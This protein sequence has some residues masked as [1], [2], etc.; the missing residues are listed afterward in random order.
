MV[1]TIPC[2]QERKYS[3]P[4]HYSDPEIKQPQ[5]EQSVLFRGFVPYPSRG[6]GVNWGE[7]RRKEGGRATLFHYLPFYYC[8]TSVAYLGS[9]I[10]N[11]E[12]G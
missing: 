2:K 6:R 7:K 10:L 1:S 3:K 8:V 4:Q 9:Y 11:A 5:E 12:C